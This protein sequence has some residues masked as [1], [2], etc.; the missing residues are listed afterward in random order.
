MKKRK[1]GLNETFDGRKKLKKQKTKLGDKVRV[2]LNHLTKIPRRVVEIDEYPIELKKKSV[3]LTRQD[4]EI[5]F[6]EFIGEHKDL[7]EVD[8]ESLKVLSSKKINNRWY[9]KYGQ[10]YKGIPVHNAMVGVDSSEDGKIDSYTADYY[11]G[12]KVASRPKVK[13]EAAAKVA[14]ESYKTQERKK[15]KWKDET[16]II[17]P[18]KVENKIKYHL[19]WKF[20]IVAEQPEP[21]LEKYFIVSALDGT[22]ITSYSA[23][24]PGAVVSGKVEGEIY[25]ENPTDALSTEPFEHQHVEIMGVGNATTNSAGNFS[26]QIWWW[27]FI[28]ISVGTANFKLEGPYARVQDVDGSDFIETKTCNTNSPCNHTWTA[29]DRDHINVF[30]HMNRFHDWLKNELGY[31]WINPW[32]GTSRFN[33]RVNDPRNNAWAGDPMLFGTNNFARSSDVIY[34]ECTHNILY[35]IYGDWIGF[36]STRI[37]AYAMDEGFAD[38]FGG[39]FTNESR[40]GEGYTNNPRNLDNNEQYPGKSAY[41]I[42]G[43]SGGEII[44][45][46]AWDF[47]QRL[48]DIYGITGA[49]IA[50]QIILEA[51]QILSMSP[52][53]YYFSDPH[54]SN[55]LSAMYRAVDNDNNLLNGFP[56]FNDIQHAFHNHGL[57]QAVLENKDSFDFSTNTPGTLTGGDLYFSGGKFWANNSGQKGVKDLG[58]IGDAD[59][60]TVAIPTAGYTRFGVNAVVG[61]TYISKAQD[62]E[63]GS[64]IVFRVND[65]SADKSTVTIEYFYRYSPYWYVA[66]LSSHEIHKPGCIWVSKM[67]PAN[68]WNFKSLEKVEDL[69]ENNGYNGCHYCLPRYDTDTLS[70]QK[71]LA[72]LSDDLT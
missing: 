14:I 51:H 9:V 37:E 33:A 5:N 53:D 68:K 58:D 42:E 57:L 55:F 41:N 3:P 45:G 69:I 65:I 61:R 56:Y 25:P 8:H 46:A 7:F 35:Q 11:P 64:Y 72:N 13:L 4:V 20:Q 50:D 60:T 1:V 12:I 16:L 10:V 24:F 27:D 26:K 29:T 30:Y 6:K 19:A 52:R 48:V 34:H 49:R 63:S 36:P 38:Y 67:S 66:N 17:Y 2:S 44:A 23:R 31:S 47:R 54:E 59:L 15:L 18:E 62:G 21:E 43:H 70:K 71:V 28:F 39:S 40:H 22:I 32:T